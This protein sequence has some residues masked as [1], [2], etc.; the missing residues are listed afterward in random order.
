MNGLKLEPTSMVMRYGTR[1]GDPGRGFEQTA[2]LSR[3]SF[4]SKYPSWTPAS[5][6]AAVRSFATYAI[7]FPWPS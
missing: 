7:H 2:V 5:R 4:S 3:H 6:V 1:K